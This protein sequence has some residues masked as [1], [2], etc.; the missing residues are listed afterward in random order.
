M[1]MTD[2][3]LL[4]LIRVKGLADEAAV[5]AAVGQSADAVQAACL[6]ALSGGLLTR[7]PRGLRLT[8]AGR[9]RLTELIAQER[10][11]LDAEA[12][13]AAY[14][15]FCAV[16]QEL[17]TAIAAWQ[18]R[19]DATP[20]DHTDPG[21]DARVIERLAAFD[22]RAAPILARLAL[23]APRLSRYGQRLSAALERVQAGDHAYVARPIID[24]YHTVWFELHEDLIAM[25]G[26]TRAAEAAAGR[27][28]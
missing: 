26:R 19:D 22:A 2:V 27:G 14:E 9:E 13:D 7:L 4:Q 11:G 10:A 18:I 1:A 8:P 15:D 17:K 23:L 20:N 25:A 28:A 21:Y 12:L 24:S 6:A 5:A 16:N 3:A